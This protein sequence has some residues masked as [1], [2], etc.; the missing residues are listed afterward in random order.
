M[1]NVYSYIYMYIEPF[2]DPITLSIIYI[3]Y[4]CI[5]VHHLG[6]RALVTW[7]LAMRSLALGALKM[8]LLVRTS[9]TRGIVTPA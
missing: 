9:S 6:P 5:I 8:S 2:I 7:S 3:S 1:Y 4:V